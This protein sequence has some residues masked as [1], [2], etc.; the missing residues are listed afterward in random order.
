[1][2]TSIT[3]EALVSRAEAW[4]KAI[5]C[6]VTFAELVAATPTG[7]IPDAIGWRSSISIL[8]ECKIS[9]AD[10]FADKNKRFRARPET[11]MGDWRFYLCPPGVLRVDDLP[12]GWGLLYAADKKIVRMHGLPIGNSYWGVPP[13]KGCKRSELML[14]YSA[15]RRLNLRGHLPSIYEPLGG[16]NAPA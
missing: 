5:G 4:L 13:H 7:E 9:R 14:M 12:P 10:F 11:G 8:I 15:L 2:Q 6:G 3:H 1:M 16:Q